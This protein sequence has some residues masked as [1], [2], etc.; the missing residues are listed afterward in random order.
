MLKNHEQIFGIPEFSPVTGGVWNF[1]PPVLD[2]V[3]NSVD[4][5]VLRSEASGTSETL[6]PHVSDTPSDDDE[7]IQNNRNINVHL[8]F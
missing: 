4:F 1:T 6:F 8:P 5:N 7:L 2:R 3:E